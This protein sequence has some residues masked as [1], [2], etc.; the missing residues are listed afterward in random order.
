M[1][2]TFKELEIPNVILITAVLFADSRGSFIETYKRSE[3]VK[4]GIREHFVQDNQSRST[5]NVLRGLHY[6]KD[7]QSQG[8]LVRCMKGNIFDVCVDLRK[9][10]KFFGKWIGIELSEENNKMLYVPPSFAHGFVVL[11][12]EADVSY[13][14]TKEYAKGLDRG[15]IWNDPTINISWVIANP[16]VSDKDRSHPVLKDADLN[17]S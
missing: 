17:F 13:K 14:C 5:R 4:A 7:P 11:S 8:K 1:P 15:I 16:I 10:S 12:D 9:S 2:F 6:Q 3:F